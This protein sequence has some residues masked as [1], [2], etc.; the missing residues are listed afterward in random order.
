MNFY[1][2]VL[3]IFESAILSRTYSSHILLEK[4]EMQVRSEAMYL[5]TEF[6]NGMILYSKKYL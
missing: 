1:H 6:E 2:L 5:R 3:K 4:L